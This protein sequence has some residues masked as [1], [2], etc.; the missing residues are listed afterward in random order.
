MSSPNTEELFHIFC[1]SKASPKDTVKRAEAYM[2]SPSLSELLRELCEKHGFAP[3]ALMEKA[4]VERTMGY[5]IMDGS[6]NP[7][8]NTLLRIIITLEADMDETQQLLR[9]GQRAQLY[10]KNRRD[11]YIICGIA[12]H[13]NI[14]QLE[15][16]LK[17]AGELGLYE[18]F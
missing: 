10:S 2:D 1:N 5:R 11:A 8:R 6:R 9:C 12:Q 4:G 7:G 3:A 13:M 16:E 14:E 18:H 17:Q 15:S